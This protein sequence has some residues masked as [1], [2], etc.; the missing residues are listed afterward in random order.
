M[1]FSQ[2]LGGGHHRRLMTGS[3]G[4]EHGVQG[5]YGFARPNVALQQSIHRGRDLQVGRDFVNDRTLTL[6]QLKR[7]TRR[8]VRIDRLVVFQGRGAQRFTAMAPLEKHRQLQQQQL[9]ERQSSASSLRFVR[10][11]R[12]MHHPVRLGQRRQRAVRAVLIMQ[13]IVELRQRRIEHGLHGSLDHCRW[14]ILRSGVD[15][16]KPLAARFTRLIGVARLVVRIDHLQVI[17]VAFDLAPDAQAHPGVELAPHPGRVEP[18]QLDRARTVLERRLDA[19]MPA[20]QGA[21]DRNLPAH[22]N[23]RLRPVNGRDE[24]RRLF[25]RLLRQLVLIAH[26]QVKDQIGDTSD[27]NLAIPP[28]GR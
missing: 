18:R 12:P 14:Q 15:R 17:A 26:R 11:G 24:I 20:A 19:R 27:G 28:R 1:L 13:M 10:I 2:Q 7:K 23:V 5:D 6:G 16:A 4:H 22:G 25:D 9:I 8:D 3:H 21:N